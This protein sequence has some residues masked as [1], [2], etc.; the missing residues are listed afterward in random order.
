VAY[1]GFSST[2]S[3]RSARSAALL[4]VHACFGHSEVLDLALCDEFLYGTD[5]V[6]NF[7]VRID[8][9]LLAASRIYRKKRNRRV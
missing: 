1:L 3:I 9:L 6:F 4:R 5:Y 8:A 7:H 2:A